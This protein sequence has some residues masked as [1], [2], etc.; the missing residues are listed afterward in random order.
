MNQKRKPGEVRDPDFSPSED[1]DNEFSSTSNSEIEEDEPDKDEEDTGNKKYKNLWPEKISQYFSAGTHE[2]RKAQASGLYTIFGA[3]AFGVV[4]SSKMNKKRVEE[5]KERMKN[6]PAGVSK[7]YW[8]AKVILDRCPKKKLKK[9]DLMKAPPKIN[10]VSPSTSTTSGTGTLETLS[11]KGT[12]FLAEVNTLNGRK[13]K[14]EDGMVDYIGKQE[15]G[16]MGITIAVGKP[17]FSIFKVVSHGKICPP[18]RRTKEIRETALENQVYSID[19][20]SF[21]LIIKK[22]WGEQPA[23]AP[24]RFYLRFG[25]N[26]KQKG[27]RGKKERPIHGTFLSR[28]SLC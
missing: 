2:A 11:E 22:Q 24:P 27:V 21:L 5:V 4:P 19:V 23:N 17:F 16:K 9:Q 28:W 15:L 13:R 26:Y 20:D 18:K 10:T 7:E 25:R 14:C 12:D 1:I 6:K 3:D 8:A